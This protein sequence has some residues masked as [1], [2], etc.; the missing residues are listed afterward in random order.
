MNYKDIII[1]VFWEIGMPLKLNSL[2]FKPQAIEKSITIQAVE[3][4]DLP[5]LIHHAPALFRSLLGGFNPVI[6]R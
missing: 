6:K 5:L 1:I 4:N 3:A 2:G